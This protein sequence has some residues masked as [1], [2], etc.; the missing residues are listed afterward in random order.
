[1]PIEARVVM[2]GLAVFI[3]WTMA[4]A[5]RSGQIFSRGIGYTADDQP[6]I[7]ALGLLSHA[8]IAVF[9]LYIAAGNALPEFALAWCP[10]WMKLADGNASAR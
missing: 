4:R 10:D 3:A 8:G 6:V 7:Y 2:G 1:M 5:V 9:C